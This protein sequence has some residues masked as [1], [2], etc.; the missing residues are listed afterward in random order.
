MTSEI[1]YSPD[2]STTSYEMTIKVPVK[3]AVPHQA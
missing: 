1:S 2:K 3:T